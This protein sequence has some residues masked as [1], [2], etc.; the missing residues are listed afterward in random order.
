MEREI[1]KV[2]VLG[3]GVMG[4]N[5]A[6]L[7]ASCGMDVVLLDIVPFDSMLSEKEIAKRDKDKKVRNKL[8]AGAL[9]KA[10]KDK[11]FPFYTKADAARGRGRQLRRR[12]GPA[13][14]LRLGR[15]GRRRAAGHQAE[16]AG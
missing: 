4:A 11:Q 3:S 2:G 9:K 12:P 14:R 15:G 7:C 5:I 8:A 1:K 6:A 10:I 13:R 16:P